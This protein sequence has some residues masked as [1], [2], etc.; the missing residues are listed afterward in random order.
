MDLLDL[1]DLVSSRLWAEYQQSRL[2][3]LK[4]LVGDLPTLTLNGPGGAQTKML[5]S[6]LPGFGSE[7]PLDLI[8]SHVKS[9]RPRMGPPMAL[10]DRS[11][12]ALLAT[13]RIHR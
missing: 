12:P 4:L 2:C 7:R 13:G 6:G 11:S 5:M 10:S 8:D 1:L 3:V 9:F